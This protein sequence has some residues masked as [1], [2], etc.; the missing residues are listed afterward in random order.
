[1]V[2]PSP[3]PLL[4]LF[5]VKPSPAL[6]LAFIHGY[7]LSYSLDFFIHGYTLSYSPACFYSWLQP[8]LLS[9][10]ILFMVKPS[11]TLLLAFIYG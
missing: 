10:L 11:S 7:T 3:T 8:L 4:A 1:M 6:L 9:C 5:M 2:T